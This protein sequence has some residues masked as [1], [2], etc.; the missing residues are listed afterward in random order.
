M[1]WNKI[2]QIIFTYCFGVLIF[3]FEKII[4]SKNNNNNNIIFFK[5]VTLGIYI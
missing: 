3:K 2:L 4:I 5:I 1:I